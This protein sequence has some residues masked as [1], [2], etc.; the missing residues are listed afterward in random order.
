MTMTADRPTILS[1]GEVLWDLFPEGERFGG[2]PANFACHAALAG[3]DVTMISAVGR[4]ERGDRARQILKSYHVDVTLLQTAEKPTGT[5][6]VEVDASGKPSFTIDTDSAWD[7]LHWADSLESTI[8]N[9]DL[10]YFGTLGQRSA[11]SRQVIR[12]CLEVA[13]EVAVPRLLDVNLRPPFFDANLIRE[14][15][16]HATI[17]KLSDEEVDLVSS[18]LGISDSNIESLLQSLLERTNL[19]SVILT[20]GAEGALFVQDKAIISQPGIQADIRD[21][22]GAGDAFTATFATRMLR[23]VEPSV[24]LRQACEQAAKVC[25]I[26]GAVP[27][28]KSSNDQL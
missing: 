14:S 18:A 4:D 8:R 21:T 12:R 25:A 13:R 1:L 3:S 5:V 17:L 27:P 15:V 9:A 16:D 20:R 26:D 28:P 6:G 7:C 23:G 19:E 2:A 24:S 10:V 11:A 22:V